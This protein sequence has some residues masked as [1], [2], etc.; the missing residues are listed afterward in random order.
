[1]ATH[2]RPRRFE[3]VPMRL[4]DLDEIM[5]IERRSYKNPWAR[6]VFIEEMDREWAHVDVLRER[7]ERRNKVIGFINYWLVRDE[8]HVLNVSVL[9]EERRKGHAS[10][11]IA[12]V[13]E[14]ARRHGSRFVTLEVRRS[15]HGALKLYRSFGFR[16]VGIRPKYYAEEG[17][18]A[19]VMLLDL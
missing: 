4:V 14:Y 17:E 7:T 6:Q 18:D 15:N 9:P 19:I 10:R 2:P 12:H 8:V 5:D 11:L 1:M 13:I 3:V 16:S